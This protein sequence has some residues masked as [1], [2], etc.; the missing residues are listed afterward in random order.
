MNKIKILHI[1]TRLD[2]GGS[3]ENTLYS[4]CELKKKGY[5]VTL[6]SGRSFD[7][8]GRI[9]AFIKSNGIQVTV[10]P[11]IV[12]QINPWKDCIAFF[13]IGKFIRKNKF[14]I[15]HTHASKAGVLGRWAAW[16]TQAD[17]IIHTPHGH[18]FYGYYG[19]YM[20]KLFIWIEKISAYITNRI[21]GLTDG[22]IAD[23]ITYNIAKPSKFTPI[24][25]GVELDTYSKADI[26]VEKTRS[27]LGLQ[28]NEICVGTITRLEPVKGNRYLI[29][30]WKYVLDKFPHAKLIIIGD[31]SEKESLHNLARRLHIFDSIIFTGMRHD[32]P[33]L[34]SIL[35]F[36]VLPSINEGMGKVLIQ[37]AAM[38][39][40]SIGSRVCGIPDVIQEG[41]TG[42]L[43]H[44]A[45]VP[46]L[47]DAICALL[48]DP[49][50]TKYLGRNA[51]KWVTDTV[52]GYGRFSKERMISKLDLI[53]KE[54]LTN[55]F[56]SI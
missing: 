32:L 39:K 23:Y 11:E 35:E 34:L 5:D 6:V 31:G 54:A 29:E 12:R 47:A 19:R 7:P 17:I 44:P 27:S 45:D 3:A 1:I 8:T 13:K 10:I 50:R 38:E 28:K 33:Q 21:I 30:A 42:L 15:V 46:A 56:Q 49:E 52:D 53:Y 41:G 37:A 25:S 9:N 22:E 14:T 51:K 55:L 24:H 40:P 26:D 20:S 18:V 2:Q 4:V 48:A 36:F 43:V 16:L